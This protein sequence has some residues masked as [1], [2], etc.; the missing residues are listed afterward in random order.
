MRKK[1]GWFT[2]IIA[3][4]VS[5]LFLS[6]CSKKELCSVDG[7]EQEVYQDGLCADHYVAEAL[8]TASSDSADSEGEAPETIVDE[9][10]EPSA[11]TEDSSELEPAEYP[12]IADGEILTVEDRG[13]FYIDFC[14]ITARVTPPAPASFYSYYDAGDGKLYVDLCVAYKNLGASDRTA[15]DVISATLLY[16]GIYEYTGFSVIEESNR[17]N[18]TYSDITDIAPLT[19]EYLHYLFNV[20][21]EVGSSTGSLEVILTIDGET[22]SYSVRDG[23]TGSVTSFSD[24]PERTSG[25]VSIGDTLKE[26]E[27]YEASIDFVKITDKVTPPYPD[28]FYTYYQA[29][30]GQVYIDFCIAYKNLTHSSVKASDVLSGKA[31][32]AGKYEYTGFSV[33]EENSREDF[34]YSNI[35]NIAPL[36]TE[37]LHYLIKVPEEVGTSSDSLEIRFSIQGNE[38]TYSYR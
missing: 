29:D 5:I 27:K 19:T 31:T 21:E 11:E 22:Y 38:Y 4:S 28:S 8:E 14:E 37:Y 1:M 3:M 35:T 33:I 15:S 13:E 30:E 2:A 24:L 10:A 32:Y 36:T 23:D 12:R 18:F 6:A 25:S 17:G 34:T 16:S 20:P 7:C 9:P 26:S